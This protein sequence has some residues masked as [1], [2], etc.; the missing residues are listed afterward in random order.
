M[1]LD[2]SD[3]TAQVGR[4]ALMATDR[5]ATI[6]TSEARNATRRSFIAGFLVRLSCSQ[7]R[8]EIVLETPQAL[9]S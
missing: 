8:T 3:P 4:K 7:S 2:A 6:T 9:V 5:I 1:T